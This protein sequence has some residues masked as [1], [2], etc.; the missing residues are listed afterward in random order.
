M[1]SSW[2]AGWCY[3]CPLSSPYLYFKLTYRTVRDC[4]PFVLPVFKKSLMKRDI[5]F[6]DWDWMF[7]E[8]EEHPAVC[9]YCSKHL[10]R[11]LD[12][13]GQ[14]LHNW[15]E[16]RLMWVAGLLPVINPCHHRPAQ[17]SPATANWPLVFPAPASI[18]SDIHKSLES[19][20]INV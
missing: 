4:P 11:G 9:W 15:W 5:L 19:P 1:G 20:V 7:D 3:I 10:E 8:V 18:I 2:L 12:R 13:S 14:T 6:L 16:C 17:A